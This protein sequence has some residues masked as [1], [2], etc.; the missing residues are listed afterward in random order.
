MSKIRTAL[1][2]SIALTLLTT[3]LGASSAWAQAA[4]D[5]LQEVVVTAT[6]RSEDI[7]DVGVS[8]TALTAEQLEAKGVEQF[9]DYG[10]SVPN[11]S[12]AI[13]AADGSL[14]GRGIAL[15]GIVGANTTGF[16]IDDTPVLETLDP[17]IVDV[18]RIEVLR[19]PQGTLYG[20]ESMGGTVRIITEQP[21]TTAFGGQVHVLGSGTEHGGFNQ[22]LEG[23]VNVPLV[24]N[25]LAVRA[26]AFYQFD[27]GYFDKAIGPYSAPP[28]QTLT[29]L[30][31]MR[32]YGGQLALRWEPLNGLSVT[33][34]IMF[35]EIQQGGSPYAY[36][37]PNNLLQREV[38]DLDTGGTDKWW[39]AS[40]TLNYTV[41][42]GT[43]V[44]STSYFERETFETEDD[45]DVL[46][47]DLGLT[48]PLPSP[49]TR[50]I[51]LH[52]FAQEIRFASS[53]PGPF[54]IIAGGFYSDST[55]PRDYEWTGQGLTQIGFPTDLAL[56]FID[57]REAKEYALFGDASYEILSGLKAT[58]GLRY[59]RDTATFNQY[60][61]G[62]FFGG[63]PST[64][65]APE[66][67][68]NGVT[69]KYLLEY[70]ATPDLLLYA[71]AAKGFR[72][73]GNNIALPPGPPP[74]GCDQDLA[75]LGLTAAEVATFKS[76]SLW[77]YEAGFKSS[78]DERRFTFNATGF[79]IEW[80]NIQQNVA[81]PL[82][83]YGVTGNSGAARS[84]GFEL[85]FDGKLLRELTLGVGFGYDNAYIT[86]QGPGT[87]QT[88]GSPV[89]QV[90][91]IT[92]ASN[93]EYSRPVTANWS[94][95]SRL[96]YSYVGGSYSANNSQLLPL[97][98]GAYAITDFRIGARN[99]RW[100]LTAFIKNLTDKHA[101]LGDAILIGA[102]VP[103]MPRFVI[104]QPLTAGVEARLRFQ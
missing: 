72:E 6:K 88:V 41:S 59:F 50:K 99:D 10:T 102:E 93:L 104:N 13:G 45:T 19:G 29:H 83:G 26:S 21:N 70:K 3:A 7:Q 89:Y 78:F 92:V 100:E 42:F 17:H 87:P 90:P 69:P 75:N 52:R 38:F 96:D 39:L 20:A 14:A 62:I 61:N 86:Q 12:F 53:F 68:E 65:V 85:E 28:T 30:G 49:I 34:R 32:Y 44:S 4:G 23:A 79:L 76:D 11:L 48:E 98:R 1:L 40:L 58:A 73:G 101:N 81:L 8:I 55:R 63:A 51:D 60:T 9:F 24:D 57:S 80:K 66:T 74:G 54:Q 43:F 18:A 84:A 25:V 97:Y 35:Q 5:A 67:S 47:L 36:N 27:D 103:G 71:S 31:S 16:Y 2:S 91:R 95:F 64:Y 37:D 94:G 33:P 56:S 46:Q 77:D 82:C 22:I 15:R